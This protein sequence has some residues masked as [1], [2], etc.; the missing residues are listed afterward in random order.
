MNSKND[1]FSCIKHL[2]DA[3]SMHKCF[4]QADMETMVQVYMLIY[5]RD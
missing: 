3:Q 1:K 5:T 2:R 4:W